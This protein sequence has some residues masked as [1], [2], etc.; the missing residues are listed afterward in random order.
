MQKP[1]AT[2]LHASNDELHDSPARN[3]L[4]FTPQ[5]HH[6]R[7]L[8]FACTPGQDNRFAFDLSVVRTTSSLAQ[9]LTNW[10]NH[11]LARIERCKADFQLPRGR[12]PVEHSWFLSLFVTD[13]VK[14]KKFS[15][16]FISRSVLSSDR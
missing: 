2:R 1:F 12:P 7:L 3:L 8:L 9:W 4:P 10:T 11:T 15:G 14:L 5:K 6:E 16:P 13:L